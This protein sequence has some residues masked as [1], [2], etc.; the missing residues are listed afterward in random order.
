MSI[1]AILIIFLTNILNKCG[2]AASF[3]L[4]TVI[5]FAP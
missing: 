1:S 4:C 3:K 5:S 2:D